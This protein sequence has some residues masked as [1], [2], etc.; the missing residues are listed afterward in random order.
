MEYS[1]TDSD[2]NTTTVKRIVTVKEEVKPETPSKLDKVENL[3]WS[4][5]TAKWDVVENATRYK[6]ALYRNNVLVVEKIVDINGQE[7]LSL[8]KEVN[9]VSY[10]FSQYFTTEGEYRFTVIAEADGYESSEVSGEDNNNSDNVN[11][12]K[13]TKPEINANDVT[14]KVGETFN[15]RQGVTAY[16]KE[17]GDLTDS[18]EVIENTVV[19]ST[20]G[21][22]SVTYKVVDKKGLETTK[23][24]VVI[25][26]SNEK[27][28]ISGA[29]DMQI[30]FGSAFDPKLGVTATDYEDK[31]LTASIVVSGEVNTSVAGEY[32]LIYS[33][34]DTD[35]NITTVKR[36]VT[37]KEEVK[38]EEP[39]NPVLP[40]DPALPED[41][42]NPEIP[43]VPQEPEL[44]GDTIK[45]EVPSVDSDKEDVSIIPD[46]KVEIEN[47]ESGKETNS[48]ELPKTGSTVSALEL[49]LLSSLLIFIGSLLTKKK[50]KK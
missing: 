36:I 14:I 41:P 50:I 32:E 34:T 7:V 23:T 15:E 31:D 29:D 16:D 39:S 43:S 20:P 33:V 49:S 13:N 47:N 40:E 2:K 46:D 12:Y 37:V 48:E 11:I 4:G 18:I 42:N 10:D 6:I 21:V 1:V 9:K 17:D 25:V 27:P 24:I 19:I 38:P 8:A 44:P 35:G 30:E 22:Y 26:L 5:M 28:V 45:P 3:I